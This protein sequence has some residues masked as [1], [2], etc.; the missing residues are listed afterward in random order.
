[1]LPSGLKPLRPTVKICDVH[2]HLHMLLTGARLTFGLYRSSYLY[3]V[4]RVPNGVKRMTIM[5]TVAAML[6]T[7][8]SAARLK[9]CFS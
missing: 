4:S 1:M 9:L 3:N 7:L 8:N 2:T 6:A 5:Q